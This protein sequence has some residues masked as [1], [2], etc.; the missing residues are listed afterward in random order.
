MHF[1]ASGGQIK[2]GLKLCMFQKRKEEKHFQ[3]E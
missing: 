1:L 3:D 2:N